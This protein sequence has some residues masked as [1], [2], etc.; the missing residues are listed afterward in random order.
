MNRQL[1]MSR[2]AHFH[3]AGETCNG[4]KEAALT[5]EEHSESALLRLCIGFS[6][7]VSLIVAL[8]LSLY[9]RRRS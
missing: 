3:V 8:G 4:P 7:G 5:I 6:L 9:L 1:A 2:R